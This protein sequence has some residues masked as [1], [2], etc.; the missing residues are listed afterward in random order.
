MK[1]RKEEE[2]EG[3]EERRGRYTLIINMQTIEMK[4]RNDKER[5]RD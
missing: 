1:W 3:D 4:K 2:R 5:E